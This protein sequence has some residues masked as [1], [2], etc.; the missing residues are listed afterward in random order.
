MKKY[1]LTAMIIATTATAAHAIDISECEKWSEPGPRG[2]WIVKCDAT[3][4][5]RELQSG[6]ATA[7]TLSATTGAIAFAIMTKDKKYVYIN[8]V[9]ND[10]GPDTTG[11]RIIKPTDDK[12]ND[13]DTYAIPLCE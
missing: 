8:V 11:Y 6:E 7:M 3:D 13:G 9:P 1:L 12:Y 10:C 4:E 2:D 5:L